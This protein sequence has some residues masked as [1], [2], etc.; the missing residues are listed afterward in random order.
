MGEREEKQ[1]RQGKKVINI[2]TNN[3]IDHYTLGYFAYLFAYA[4]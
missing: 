3:N 4:L 2:Y 1:R